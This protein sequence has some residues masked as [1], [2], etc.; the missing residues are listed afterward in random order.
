LF[1]KPRK[2][3]EY[4]YTGSEISQWGYD[5]SLP[6]EITIDD[7]I[8]KIKWTGNYGGQFDLTYGTAQKTIIVDSLF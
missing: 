8:I 4:I 2:T 3:Y 6:M 7:K 5:S 1:I